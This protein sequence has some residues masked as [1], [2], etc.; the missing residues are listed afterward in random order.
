MRDNI[1]IPLCNNILCIIYQ[2]NDAKFDFLLKKL[3]EGTMFHD[4]FSVVTGIWY[5]CQS[6]AINELLWGTGYV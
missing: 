5:L 4:A 1:S 6:H 2:Y 3:A